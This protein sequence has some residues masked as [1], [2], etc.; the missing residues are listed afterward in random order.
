MNRNASY[1]EG[2]LARASEMFLSQ[3]PLTIF[4]KWAILGLFFVYFHLFKQTLQFLQHICVKNVMSIK[5]MAPGF[6]PTTFGT[7]VSSHNHQTRVP[8]LFVCQQGQ[9]ASADLLICQIFKCLQSRW[10]DI[11]QWIRLRSP[12]CS[13]WF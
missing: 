3:L 9:C 5:I 12:S 11:A 7:Q 1:R 6:E 4:L 13:P 10:S 2:N 8:E